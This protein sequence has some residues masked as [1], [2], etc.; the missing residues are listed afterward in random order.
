MFNGTPSRLASGLE[1][2]SVQMGKS[3]G[4][5][6][7][8]VRRWKSRGP[9]GGVVGWLRRLALPGLLAAMN[10]TRMRGGDDGTLL[11]LQTGMVM[12]K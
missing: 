1:A 4:R 5:N 12:R 2:S 3:G 10:H 6:R 11:R 9:G 7:W 8:A